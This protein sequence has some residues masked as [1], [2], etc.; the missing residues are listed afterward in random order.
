MDLNGYVTNY[1]V[2]GGNFVFS[3]IPEVTL[4]IE[5]VGLN[6]VRLSWPAAAGDYV[7]HSGRTP[8]GPMTPVPQLPELIGADRVVTLSLPSSNS[9]FRLVR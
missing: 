8:D 4:Q 5:L 7:L 9:F 3:V 1:F 6:Q 2:L